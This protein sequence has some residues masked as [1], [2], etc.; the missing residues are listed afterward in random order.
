MLAAEHPDTDP[1]L[2]AL[3]RYHRMEEARHLS[4]ART[5]LPEA[6]ARAGWVE[7]QRIRFAAPFLIG[8]LW[9]MFVHPG[10]YAT[11]G[12][13]PWKTWNAVQ[14]AAPTDRVA[15]AGHAPGARGAARRRACSAAAGSRGAGGRSAASTATVHRATERFG[16]RRFA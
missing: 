14:R 11:V 15:P 5:V 2:A 16:P 10:V 1:L 12:L 3:N 6:W 7:R 8:Q 13:P 9:Q 4:F